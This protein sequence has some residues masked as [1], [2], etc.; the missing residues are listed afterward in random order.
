M[1]PCFSGAPCALCLAQ[2]W[3]CVMSMRQR[4]GRAVGQ[5]NTGPQRM[6]KGEEPAECGEAGTGARVGG[7]PPSSCWM[8]DA[9]CGWGFQPDPSVRQDRN[10]TCFRLQRKE[11]C[12]IGSG[13][14]LGTHH[15]G[16]TFMPSQ[17]N[18][19]LPKSSQSS[20]PLGET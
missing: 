12:L 16:W 6:R 5:Q 14:W 7:C 9:G 18:A 17:S 15:E 19:T 8:Q 20:W 4:A 3:L 1:A 2:L 13:C 10:G 11:T